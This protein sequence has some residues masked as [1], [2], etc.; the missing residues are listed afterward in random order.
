MFF[1]KYVKQNIVKFPVLYIVLSLCQISSILAIILSIGILADVTVKSTEAYNEATYFSYYFNYHYH[2]DTHVTA[3]ENRTIG[4]IKQQA[5]ELRDFLG[6]DLDVLLFGTALE[7][8]GFLRTFV[9]LFKDYNGLVR[10]FANTFNIGIDQLPSF[11]EYNNNEKVVIAGDIV[12][13]DGYIE[14]K[15]EMYRITGRY[16]GWGFRTLFDTLPENT[17]LNGFSILLSRIISNQRAQNIH[18]KIIELFGADLHIS[19]VPQTDD[20]LNQQFRAINI[21]ASV[22]IIIIATINS[23]LI[24]KFMISLRIKNFI[25]YRICGKTKNGCLIYCLSENAI[26]SMISYFLSVLIFKMFIQ[27]A[28]VKTY[29]FIDI[30]FSQLSTFTWIFTLYL[31]VSIIINLIYVFPVISRTIN[32]IYKEGV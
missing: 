20:L 7:E 32:S 29:S 26:I 1:I 3:L 9:S 12:G 8:E 25:V 5:H 31:I 27:P 28:V 4:E 13:I 17:E 11:D 24:F 22:L 2:S 14:I 15:G 6:D 21:F 16:D 18:D 23:M 10:H 30:Y 19:N